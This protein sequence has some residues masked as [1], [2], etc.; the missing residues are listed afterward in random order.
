[1]NRST[2]RWAAASM[3]ATALTT[4]LALMGCTASA[5]TVQGPEVHGTDAYATQTLPAM[6]PAYP[7][8]G[9]WE[10]LFFAGRQ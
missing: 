7:I 9:G 10:Q 1:M 8:S 5:D 4:A 6:V 2:K 3:V